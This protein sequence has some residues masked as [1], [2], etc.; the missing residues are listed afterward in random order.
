MNREILCPITNKTDFMNYGTVGICPMQLYNN[1]IVID[2]TSGPY[3]PPAKP[4]LSNTEKPLFCHASAVKYNT[5][6]LGCYKF[7]CGKS[8]PR[9]GYFDLPSAST[10]SCSHSAYKNLE[11]YNDLERVLKHNWY[12]HNTE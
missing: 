4:L 1:P 3:K 7:N 2:R 8:H 9:Y 5:P 10:G 12:A 6:D 11:Y